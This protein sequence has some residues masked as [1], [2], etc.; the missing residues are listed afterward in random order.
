MSK[1]DQERAVILAGQMLPKQNEKKQGSEL[2]RMKMVHEHR[3]NTQLARSMLT[4]L[5]HPASGG[6]HCT[7]THT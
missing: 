4:W 7:F 1:R 2:K 6:R 5:H 3:E